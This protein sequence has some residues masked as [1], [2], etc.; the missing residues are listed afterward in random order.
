MI[1]R[2]NKDF[3]LCDFHHEDPILTTHVSIKCSTIGPKASAGK[4]VSAPTIKTTITRN[5]IKSGVCVGNVPW[6]TGTIFFLESEP[7]IASIGMASQYRAKNM[8][9]PKAIL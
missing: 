4:N 7:A 9:N 1:D 3:A 6:L 5:K 8:A 2:S